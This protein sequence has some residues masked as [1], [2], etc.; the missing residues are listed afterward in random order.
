M[1]SHLFFRIHYATTP[2]R[3]S[4]LPVIFT[5]NP[6]G[7][8][9]LSQEVTNLVDC[10]IWSRIWDSNPVVRKLAGECFCFERTHRRKL[11]VCTGS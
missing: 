10:E 5:V 11:L 2:Q 6:S 4:L 3:I 9:F 7:R 8:C 1:H